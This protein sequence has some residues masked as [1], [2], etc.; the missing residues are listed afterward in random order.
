MQT[1]VEA[2]TRTITWC[3][4]TPWSCMQLFRPEQEQPHDALPDVACR[5]WFAQFSLHQLHAGRTHQVR[6]G[7]VIRATEEEDE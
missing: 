2:R 4:R 1:T 6:P 5:D 3:A 7:L